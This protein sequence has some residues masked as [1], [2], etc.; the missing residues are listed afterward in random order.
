MTHLPSE[1]ISRRLDW[2]DTDAAGIH[3]NTLVNRFVEAAEASLMMRLGLDGYFQVAP[4]VRFEATYEAPLFFWQEV[5]TEVR[6]IDVGRTSLTFEFEMWGEEHNGR[7]RTRAAFGS[8]VTV[9]VPGGLPG[10]ID[11]TAQ[12]WPDEWRALLG[13]QSG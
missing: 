1:R 7:P 10:A 5:T 11:S 9:H 12:P 4:R 6:I 2:I 3:H 13:G 8:Y